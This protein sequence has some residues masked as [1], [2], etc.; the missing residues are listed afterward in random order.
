MRNIFTLWRETMKKRPAS[1]NH[2]QHFCLVYL[3]FSRAFFFLIEVQLFPNAVWV[4]TAQGTSHTYPHAP[5]FL[6]FP[7]I[8]VGAE[9]PAESRVRQSALI[10][11]LL[12]TEVCVHP[13]QSLIHPT[14]SFPTHAF[15]NIFA[16]TLCTK[17]GNLPSLSIKT[18]EFSHIAARPL[19]TSWN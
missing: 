1:E 15:L 13:S 6:D 4:S 10:S 11:Y 3:S 5:S 9:H 8:Q 14:S 12:Y 18:P 7:P 19:Q 2:C 16:N 17:F